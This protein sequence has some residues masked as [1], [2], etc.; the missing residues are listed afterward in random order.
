MSDANT[1]KPVTDPFLLAQLNKDVKKEPKQEKKEIGLQPVTDPY[2]LNK[3]N[4]ATLVE[5]I[6]PN[7]LVDKITFEGLSGEQVDS[8]TWAEWT[9]PASGIAASIAASIPATAKGYE[10]GQNL[11]KGVPDVGYGKLVK[12]GVPIVT[13]AGFGAFAGGFALG[14]TEFSHDYVESLVTGETFDPSSAFNQAWDAAATDMLFSSAASLGF[15]AVATGLK[16]LR[17]LVTTPKKKNISGKAGLEDVQIKQVY[18]LQNQLVEM[19][20][21]LMP[22]MVTDKFAPKLLEDISRVS[23]FTRGTVARYYEVYGEFMGKQIDQMTSLFSNASPRQSGKVLQA[24]ISQN[25]QALNKIVEPLYAGL[26]IKG[27]GITVNAREEAVKRAKELKQLYRAQPKVD[28]KTGELIPQYIYK[29]SAKKHLD[30]LANIPDDLN[31]YEAHQRLSLVKKEIDDILSS[32]NRDSNALSILNATRDVLQDAMT[33]SAQKLSP[34]LKKEYDEITDYYAQGRKVIGA[35]WLRSVMKSNDPAKVGRMLTQ[36]GLS[37]G[38]INVKD[39]MKIAKQFKSDLPKPPKGASK[40]EVL[41]YREMVKN[42]SEDPL[43]GIRRGFLDEI[44]RTGADDSLRSVAN[45]E[46]KLKNPRFRETFNTLFAGTPVPAR[47]DEILANLSILQR[48][49]KGQQG[50]QLTIAQAEQAAISPSASITVLSKAILPAL[51]SSKAIK[52]ESVTQ[53]INLQ[54]VA[55][56]ASNKGKPL[57]KEYY[58][59]MQKLLIKT[60]VTGTL[61]APIYEAL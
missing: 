56:A 5:N 47:I 20:G 32:S 33:N 27:K 19:G 9:K 53:L 6:D 52:P 59:S 10:W 7:F 38:I 42:L 49:D 24:F 46:N 13:G 1:L 29:G 28:P 43:V 44:L 35:Q 31:F 3:L 37:E 11:V 25:E 16:G 30:Y 50:F 45:F 58:D 4:S 34:A 39:L 60:G 18:K 12:K 40:A 15:P 51:L 21:S 41:R 14:A 61:V 54:K 26:S 2:L 48:A 57:P 36:D 22:S 17:K 55:I 8:S 23:R